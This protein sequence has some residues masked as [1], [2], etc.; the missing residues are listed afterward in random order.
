MEPRLKCSRKGTVEVA[1]PVTFGVLTTMVAFVPLLMV[2][3]VRGAIFSQ[4]PMIVIPVLLFSL[5]ESKWILPAHLS[6]IRLDHEGPILRHISRIQR[7]FA[8]GLETF[9]FRIYRPV[10]NLSL[11][12]RY[13]TVAIFCVGGA[14]LTTLIM[15]GWMRWIFPRIQSEVARA[16]LVMPAG[17]PFVTTSAYVDR[18]TDAALQQDKYRDQKLGK[19]W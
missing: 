8:D 17:T 9:I 15:S 19:V 11:S 18:M 12:E 14:L 5:I 4:I 2:E 1:V 16:T 10:L 6:G 13:L 3:G 7:W